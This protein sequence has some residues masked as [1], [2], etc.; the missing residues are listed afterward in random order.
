MNAAH[1][2]RG[3][4]KSLSLNFLFSKRLASDPLLDHVA[5]PIVAWA[6]AVQFNSD[7]KGLRAMGS[8]FAGATAMLAKEGP[9]ALVGRGPAAACALACHR[10]GWTATRPGLIINDLQQ[11]LDLG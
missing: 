8:A 9:E 4:G 2:G 5:P 11:Q 1:H 6:K 7:H 10:L 3:Q